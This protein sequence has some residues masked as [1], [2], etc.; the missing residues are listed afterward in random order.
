MEKSYRQTGACLDNPCAVLRTPVEEDWAQIRYILNVVA[1]GDGPANPDQ[2]ANLHKRLLQL[3]GNLRTE[4]RPI[5]QD[6]LLKYLESNSRKFFSHDLPLLAALVSRLDDFFPSGLQF[7]TPENPQVHLRKIQALTLIAAAFLGVIPHNQRAL[8]EHHP[9]K[10]KMNLNKFDMFY[11]GFMEREAK[12]KSVLMYFESMRERL[13]DCWTEMVKTDS[14]LTAPCTSV[15]ECSR[16]VDGT[17]IAPTDEL[18]GFYR[19]TNQAVDFVWRGGS[20]TGTSMAV[21]IDDIA[22]STKPLGD[23]NV[24]P[25][26]DLTFAD[27]DLQV[28]FAD[29]YLGGLSMFENHIAQEELIF[30]T[31]PEMLPVMLFSDIMKANEAVIVK[32]VERF[33]F[34]RGYEWSFKIEQ[35]AGR[36]SKL[37]PGKHHSVQGVV[38]LDSLGRR[39]VTIVGMDAV[40]FFDKDKQYSQKMVDRELLKATVGFKG[41][42]YEA[43]V[44]RSHKAVATGLWGCGVF[45][46]DVELKALIQWLAASYLGRAVNFY[47]P[48]VK[49]QK[50]MD[51]V[52][53]KIGRTYS[54][55]ADLYN[56]IQR[57][58]KRRQVGSSRWSL[59]EQLV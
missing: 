46:G 11:R 41:D 40:Q 3:T 14:V 45:N 42:P 29:Q 34:S 20:V 36:W 23:F 47:S 18:I 4:N 6:A 24:L 9:K 12:F 17:S 10:F 19:Q 28:D 5:R 39:D 15:C 33:V 26:R 49:Y 37:L 51:H 27:G 52:I 43:T 38:P 32:G 58:V 13:G 7:I 57:A 54:T 55:V 22:R 50:N 35:A 44:S 59:W 8:L 21:S 25:G 53:S 1:A 2:L 31:Y 30:I 16:L 56:A 48:V